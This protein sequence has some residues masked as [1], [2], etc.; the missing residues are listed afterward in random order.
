MR[1]IISLLFALGLAAPAAAQW[2]P[3]TQSNG[4]FPGYVTVGGTLQVTGQTML[5]SPLVFS[6]GSQ[7]SAAAPITFDSSSS[8]DSGDTSINASSFTVAVPAFPQK[9]DIDLTV[10]LST[11]PLG[12]QYLF[13]CW[14]PQ[15]VTNHALIYETN[16]IYAGM[17]NLGANVGPG[18]ISVMAG[19]TMSVMGYLDDWNLGF[20]MP[21]GAQQHDVLRFSP[22]T[23]TDW[24][25]INQ[26][27][28]KFNLTDEGWTMSGDFS[29]TTEN[30]TT[31][32]L[33]VGDE[34][35]LSVATET[36]SIL[37][38]A[39]GVN[40]TSVPKCGFPTSDALNIISH[41]SWTVYDKE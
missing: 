5:E 16:A 7:M 2:Y 27:Y 36:T 20:G 12:N 26:N 8:F 11:A 38:W 22:V 19:S 13:F 17:P 4:I 37:F 30:N 18:N 10:S 35:V 31:P 9:F 3:S 39:G 29:G 28:S 6:D 41:Y 34:Y 15:P 14:Q 1:R 40:S 23:N 32:A 25:T 24:G 21:P 33:A